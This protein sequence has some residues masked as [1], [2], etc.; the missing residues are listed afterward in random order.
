MVA[1]HGRAYLEDMKLSVIAG[2]VLVPFT[3]FSMWVV[4]KYG[5][6]GFLALAAREPWALQMLLDL[7]IAL[8]IA[9]GWLR[10]DAKKR[11]IAA[12]PYVIATAVLGSPAILAYI[13][14]RGL[15]ARGAAVLGPSP[16]P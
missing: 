14:H 7:V 3:T 10:A 5:Y 13:V 15:I 8:A 12:W 11:G 4:A 16:S 6:L 1:P 9:L 2:I